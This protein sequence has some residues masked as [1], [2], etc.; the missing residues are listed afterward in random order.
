MGGLEL[1]PVAPGVPIQEWYLNRS[2]VVGPDQTR[3][4][5]NVAHEP[6]LSATLVQKTLIPF[7]ESHQSRGI[8]V[9]GLL[10]GLVESVQRMLC[11]LIDR[12]PAVV[13]HACALQPQYLHPSLLLRARKTDFEQGPTAPQH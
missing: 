11:S 12:Y 4:F 9:L 2:G 1:S 3:Q 7:L 10:D 6:W 5:L 8:V 13:W